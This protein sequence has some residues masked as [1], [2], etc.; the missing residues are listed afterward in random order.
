MRYQMHQTGLDLNIFLTHTDT[1]QPTTTS[2]GIGADAK[3][4]KSLRR[5]HGLPLRSS[6]YED[7]HSAENKFERFRGFWK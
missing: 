2:D 1:M 3:R 7:Y 6:A 4:A 5:V